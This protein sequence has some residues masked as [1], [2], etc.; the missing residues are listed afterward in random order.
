[1]DTQQNSACSEQIFTPV[2]ENFT[3][4]MLALLATFKRSGWGTMS[5]TEEDRKRRRTVVLVSNIGFRGVKR[6]GEFV[7]VTRE[8]DFCD[9]QHHPSKPHFGL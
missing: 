2:L 1:M 9:L 8:L 5:L 6:M 7:R 4:P 3:Q